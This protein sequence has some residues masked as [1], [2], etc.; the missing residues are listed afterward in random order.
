MTTTKGTK[1]VV[2]AA[3]DVTNWSTLERL[4]VSQALYEF[5]VDNMPHVA[6]LMSSHA[7]LSRPKNFFT[8]NVS[9]LRYI[10]CLA[11]AY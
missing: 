7:M 5:G 9:D 8:F 10:C 4:I 1:R 3:L 2:E 6:T 11:E